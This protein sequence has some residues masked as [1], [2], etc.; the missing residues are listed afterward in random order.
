ML[1]ARTH[2]WHLY[3]WGRYYRG[4]SRWN[5]LIG[6]PP[7]YLSTFM[8]MKSPREVSPRFGFFPLFLKGLLTKQL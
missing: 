4:T 8:Q 6:I 5:R 3:V 7:I 1:D 2:A